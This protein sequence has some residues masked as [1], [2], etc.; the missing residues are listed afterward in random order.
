MF[1][2]DSE[3]SEEKGLKQDRG[4]VGTVSQLELCYGLRLRSPQV[5]FF[6]LKFLARCK[7]ILTRYLKK[8]LNF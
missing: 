3:G 6:Q 2:L 8:D 7:Q 4:L 5:L 1:G